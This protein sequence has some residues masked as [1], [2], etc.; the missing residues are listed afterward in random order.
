MAA[1]P[2]REITRHPCR[3]TTATPP[4]VENH[5]AAD[6]G[7]VRPC[8]VVTKDNSNPVFLPQLDV[9]PCGRDVPDDSADPQA[10]IASR[11]VSIL[12]PVTALR[13]FIHY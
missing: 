11:H 4:C 3:G 6:T 5:A 8:R 12:A 2:L 10:V 9:A 7:V 13:F 1:V